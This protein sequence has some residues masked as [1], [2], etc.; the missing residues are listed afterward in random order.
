MFSSINTLLDYHVDGYI[1][2]GFMSR[3]KLLRNVVL[4]IL[5]EIRR[6][7]R[8]P[9]LTDIISY[10]KEKHPNNNESCSHRDMIKEKIYQ[11]YSDN[12]ISPSK[13]GDHKFEKLSKYYH[14]LNNN[15]TF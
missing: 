14:R 4:K 2:S 15:F 11:L 8:K 6:E 9:R 5:G 12:Y 1:D 10:I 7:K 3:E 13:E